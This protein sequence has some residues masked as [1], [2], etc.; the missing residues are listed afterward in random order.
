VTTKLN[1]QRGL[2]KENAPIKRKVEPDIAEEIDDVFN[3]Q[4]A[5]A[6]FDRAPKKSKWEQYLNEDELNEEHQVQSTKLK[7]LI[8]ISMMKMM[9]KIRDLFQRCLKSQRLEQ[10]PRKSRRCPNREAKL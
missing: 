1:L 2:A 6:S 8:Y 10:N 4:S 5:S 9:M 3:Q 7:N